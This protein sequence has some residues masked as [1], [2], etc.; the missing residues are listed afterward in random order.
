M[1]CPSFVSTFLGK[2]GSEE[3]S[4]IIISTPTNDTGD[5]PIHL[6]AQNSNLEIVSL[7][8]I[9]GSDPKSRDRRGRTIFH[10]AAMDETTLLKKLISDFKNPAEW[11]FEKDK[12]GKMPLILAGE[13]GNVEAVILLSKLIDYEIYNRMLREGNK[14][15]HSPVKGPWRKVTAEKILEVHPEFI[16]VPDPEGDTPLI[17]NVKSGDVEMVL[18][19]IAHGA[20]IHQEDKQG[21]NPL[22]Y[23][24]QKEE[25]SLVKLFLALGSEY[26]TEKVKNEFSNL[27]SGA[28]SQI[29]DLLRKIQ[30]EE[31]PN[32]KNV[33]DLAQKRIL[34]E[35]MNSAKR[36]LRLLSLDGGGIR[37]LA[38][39][40]LLITIESRIRK[41][42]NKENI[43]LINFFD[44]IAGTSTG[45]IIG[46]SLISGKSTMDILR[47]YLR[48][49]DQVFSG[50]RPYDTRRLEHVLQKEFGLE[51]K[52]SEIVPGQ[53][54][55]IFVTTTNAKTVPPELVLLRNYEMYGE[56]STMD[57]KVWKA[58]RCS[59]AAPTYFEAVD[60]AFLDGGLMANNPCSDLIVEVTKHSEY[61]R[62]KVS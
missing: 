37:G 52:M 41:K 27:K 53:N 20:D 35:A 21:K 4:K 15:L 55:R 38:S 48:F 17:K 24:I 16:E 44:W 42:L 3:K 54:K 58:A 57:A 33:L 14:P 56:S 1:G 45:A 8:L 40:L 11:I 29:E 59:S 25:I 51:T 18:V 46:L 7:L 60:S 13:T 62:A 10:L 5:L 30:Q 36:R 32:P 12:E 6:A 9:L 28:R 26:R 19:L 47:L 2:L 49:R 61:L 23:S 50:K 31:R 39:I 34:A 22:I 43:K